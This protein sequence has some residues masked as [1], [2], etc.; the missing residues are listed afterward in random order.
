MLRTKGTVQP[1]HNEECENYILKT[2]PATNSGA[3]YLA[4]FSRDMGHPSSWQGEFPES[5][6][7]ADPEA[8]ALRSRLK[9]R[10]VRET[11]D[12]LERDHPA[13]VFRR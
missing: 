5:I 9:P 11:I 6:S 13:G 10:H 8:R 7:R 3:P 1:V 4:R 2:L 12:V